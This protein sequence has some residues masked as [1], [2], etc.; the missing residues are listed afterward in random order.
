MYIHLGQDVIVS[1]RSIIGIFDIDTCS[2]SKWT[3][4]FLK[5]AQHKNQVKNVSAD[6]PKSFTVTEESGRVGVYISQ[7]STATLEKRAE[8]MDTLQ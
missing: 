1:G 4:G 7:I 8:F 2:V 3:K 5:T 6:L